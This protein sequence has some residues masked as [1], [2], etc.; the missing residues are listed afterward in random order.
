MSSKQREHF[1]LPASLPSPGNPISMFNTVGCHLDKMKHK[2]II[3]IAYRL[4]KRK[5]DHG[6]VQRRLVP[7]GT[8]PENLT[9]RPQ[10]IST[11]G[12]K[13]NAGQG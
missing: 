8:R 1:H 5:A 13:P 7:S 9:E 12:C 6:V 11:P 4:W 2:S 3:E 10:Q